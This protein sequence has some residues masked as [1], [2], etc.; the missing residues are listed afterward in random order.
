MSFIEATQTCL[1]KSTPEDIAAVGTL[2]ADTFQLCTEEMKPAGAVVYHST[3]LFG[4]SPAWPRVWLV[5][6]H[7]MHPPSGG[8]EAS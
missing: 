1:M 5:A 4:L 6:N 3:S 2:G 7:P 8:T